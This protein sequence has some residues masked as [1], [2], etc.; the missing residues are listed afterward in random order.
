VYLSL[1]CMALDYLT[2]PGEAMFINVEHLFSH[3][4]LIVMHRHY[5]LSAHTHALLCLGAWSLLGFIKTEDVLAVS[6]LE[7]VEGDGAVL[8]DSWDSIT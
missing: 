2:I 3:G 4:C 5:R 7:D 8:E 6:T 1:S